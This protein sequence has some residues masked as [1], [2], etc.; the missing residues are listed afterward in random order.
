[1]ILGEPLKMIIFF[2]AN[3]TIP[4]QCFRPTDHCFQW[5]VNGF[6][7]TQPSSLTD[8]QPQDHCF[9]WFFY[10]F[11]V[12]QP[13]ISILV[14]DGHGPLDQWCNGFDG[15]F[16]SCLPTLYFF[17]DLKST[18][19]C[20]QED[21]NIAEVWFFTQVLQLVGRIKVYSIVPTLTLVLELVE[22]VSDCWSNPHNLIGD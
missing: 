17:K 6:W 22:A 19:Y 1:M 20:L 4:I 21:N 8:F 3:P 16:T 10:G 15:S 7:V 11:G 5:F 13:L 14:F 2:C 18:N 9:Q 12:I